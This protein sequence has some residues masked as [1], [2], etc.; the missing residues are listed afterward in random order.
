VEVWKEKA[1]PPGRKAPKKR[2][3]RRKRGNL[4]KFFIFCLLEKIRKTG[5]RKPGSEGVPA[6]SIGEVSSRET[7]RAR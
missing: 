5:T 7:R 3:I 1:F 6:F 4:G 2:A